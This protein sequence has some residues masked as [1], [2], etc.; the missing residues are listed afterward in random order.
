L[1]FLSVTLNLDFDFLY[2]P[3]DFGSVYDFSH[4]G[5]VVYPNQPNRNP[6]VRVYRKP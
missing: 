1:K 6:S 2:E 3:L 4:G 5:F